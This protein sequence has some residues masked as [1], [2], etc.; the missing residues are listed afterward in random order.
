VVATK[1]SITNWTELEDP[2]SIFD[3]ILGLYT[4]PFNISNAN[5][6]HYDYSITMSY[7]LSIVNTTGVT[8]FG[9]ASRFSLHPYFYKPM[10]GVAGNCTAYLSLVTYTIPTA[11]PPVQI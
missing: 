11:S 3:P 4:T 7:E 6:Q 5:G 2:Q 10:L 8:C 1:I 9:S